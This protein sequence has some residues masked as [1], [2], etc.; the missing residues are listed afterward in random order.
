MISSLA[1]SIALASLFVSPTALAF[2]T[3]SHGAARCSTTRSSSVLLH[4]SAAEDN[5]SQQRPSLASSPQQE[6]EQQLNNDNTFDLPPSSPD[7]QS[8]NDNL[9][10][11]GNTPRSS[12]FHNLETLE[13]S[14]MRQSR[15]E[16]ERRS[17]SI[18]TSS[19]SD[20]Y[21]EL[22][23]E[24]SQLEKDLQSALDV[25]MS[26]GAVDAIRSMLRRA[27]SKDPEHVYK[28]T[29]GAARSAERMGNVE[30]VEKYR[31]ESLKARKS[32]PQ[33]NLEGLWVGKY[34]SHGFEMINVTYSGDQLI[35]YK[36]T[37][38][39]NIP[40]GEISFTANLS[41][42]MDSDIPSSQQQQSKLDPILLSESS[43]KKWG[44]KRLPRFP[45][46]GHAA[47]PGYINH[48]FM[49]GQLVVIGE[50]DYFSFAWVPLEH[51]IFFGRPSPELTLKMLREGG[52]S[53]LTAGVGLGV[54]ALDASLKEQTQYVSRCLEVTSDTFWD[55][56][57]EGKVDPFSCIWH[58]DEAEHCYF[59]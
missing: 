27:Q 24:I 46:Q 41:P 36:V 57:K 10:L 3:S 5:N 16:S 30:E 43:A 38:D 17:N 47:E 18:Y 20:A 21:W 1:K 28:V 54:P 52:G 4:A 51:Q 19:G 15:L 55:E 35:A 40:R 13:P 14:Y 31:D 48:Q 9:L 45:G 34:G 56:E 58:G 25:N 39:K 44:T 49:A 42:N 53:A 23:D 26:D 29:C 22:Q 6:Q 59:E 12:E 2:T 37:G 33:F 50:G 7:A 8:T 32:L 11:H